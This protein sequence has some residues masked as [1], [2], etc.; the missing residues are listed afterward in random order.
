MPHIGFMSIIVWPPAP[1][2]KQ[3]NAITIST[4]NAKQP[5]QQM[6]SRFLLKIQNNDN[7]KCNHNFYGKYKTITTTNAIT[8]STENTKQ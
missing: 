3:S 7:N 4:G 2:C 8:I 5:Q 6:Q 1:V